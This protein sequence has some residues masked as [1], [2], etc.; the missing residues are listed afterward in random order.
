VGE[1]YTGF[2]KRISLGRWPA[3]RLSKLESNLRLV[4]VVPYDI[5]VCRT[6]G[7]I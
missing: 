1:Q 6:Y 4:T 3:T 2:L 7:D 5:E